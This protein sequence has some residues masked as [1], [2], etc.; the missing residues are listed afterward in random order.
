MINSWYAQKKRGKKTLCIY[1]H[2]QIKKLSR[3]NHGTDSLYQA[4]HAMIVF[5]ILYMSGK[6][7]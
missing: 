6:I 7:E 1:M 3:M 4:V 5:D 2:V